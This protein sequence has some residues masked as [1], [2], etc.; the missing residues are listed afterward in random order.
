MNSDEKKNRKENLRSY[1][2]GPLT[3]LQLM[4]VIAILGGLITWLLSHFFAV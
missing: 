1:R 4:L 3:V 2:T